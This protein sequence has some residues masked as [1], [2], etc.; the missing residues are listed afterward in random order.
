MNKLTE[1]ETWYNEYEKIKYYV[2]IPNA[3]SDEWINIKTFDTKE[4]AIK[5]AQEI[6]GADEN[7]LISIISES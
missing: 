7:G 3:L 2:D 1:H 5:F 4:E 6:F